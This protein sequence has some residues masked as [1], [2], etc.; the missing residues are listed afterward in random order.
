MSMTSEGQWWNGG[1]ECDNDMEL[2]LRVSQ[3]PESLAESIVEDT[4]TNGILSLIDNLDDLVC[5]YDFTL[6]LAV[7]LLFKLLGQFKEEFSELM[8]YQS[9][10]MA[11]EGKIRVF[12]ASYVASTMATN[13]D[14]IDKISE[15]LSII[16]QSENLTDIVYAEV[17]EKLEEEFKSGGNS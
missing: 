5:D 2:T 10:D 3:T 4:S 11:E 12:D 6:S 14:L 17:A 1:R 7:I 15:I 16:A 9:A 8:D 13:N